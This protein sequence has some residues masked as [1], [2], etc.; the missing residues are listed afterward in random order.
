MLLIV[1]N[2]NDEDDSVVAHAP[3]VTTPSVVQHRL[4]LAQVA[5]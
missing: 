3:K 2:L 4:Q 1:L 5:P